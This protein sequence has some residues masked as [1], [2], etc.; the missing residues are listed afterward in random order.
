M[1]GF[2]RLRAYVL[3]QRPLRETSVIAELVVE[4]EGR[5]AAVHRPGRTGPARPFMRYLASVRGRGDLPTL[6]ALEESG[7]GYSGRAALIDGLYMN[8]LL[9]KMLPGRFHAP[10]LWSVYDEA[11]A[12]VFSA[13]RELALRRFELRLLALAGCVFVAD[14][15]DTLAKER[16]YRHIPERAPVPAG[17]RGPD[18]VQGATFAAL[19]RGLPDDTAPDT[20]DEAARLL[21]HLLAQQIGGRRMRAEVLR[22]DRKC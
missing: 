20:L 7:R 12:G 2:D 19:A 13:N 4:G 6:T 5:V 18:C 9:L 3:H 11:L 8:E 17:T 22:Y 15:V 16:F 14:Q 21:R 10:E 1:S